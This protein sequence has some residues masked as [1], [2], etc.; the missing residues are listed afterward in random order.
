MERLPVP[1]REE[2]D[3]TMYSLVLLMSL[4]GGGATPAVHEDG[5]IPPSPIHADHVERHYRYWRGCYGCNGGCYGCYGSSCYGC[6]G[7]CYGSSCYGCWGG[8]YGWSYS[9]CGCCGGWYGSAPY[10]YTRSY[11]L[12]ASPYATYPPLDTGTRGPEKIRGGQEQPKN[13]QDKNGGTPEGKEEGSSP[14]ARNSAAPAT[15]IVDLPADATLM[16]DEHQT[17]TTSGS[18]TFQTPPLDPGLVFY[19]TMKAQLRRNGDLLSVTKRVSVRAG[20]ETRIG[21]DFATADVRKEKPR[22]QPGPERA[23]RK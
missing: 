21:F 3:S 19:Y 14:E 7:G 5:T 9:C 17:Q 15:V 2:E 22:P 4:A 1:F 20:E 8:Y 11:Y 16:V 23:V 12:P 6:W 18:R 10:G 13:P